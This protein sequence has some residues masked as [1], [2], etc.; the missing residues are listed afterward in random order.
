MHR[1]RQSSNTAK[2]QP[3]RL[4][5]SPDEVRAARRPEKT[6]V[7]SPTRME[8]L[9]GV[10]LRDL[11]PGWR[12][13]AALAADGACWVWGANARGELGPAFSR[14]RSIVRP[15]RLPGL[16]GVRAIAC[17]GRHALAVDAG[18]A[19]SVLRRQNLLSVFAAAP[20][21]VSPLALVAVSPRRPSW[22]RRGG[23]AAA[24][25]V[26][27][28]RRRRGL[29]AAPSRSRRGARRGLSAAPSA[30]SRRPELRRPR[31]P[32]PYPTRLVPT[33]YKRASLNAGTRGARTTTVSS[34]RRGGPTRRRR[35]G[36]CGSP[37]R[38]S[39]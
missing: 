24:P 21:A 27:S 15:R 2:S 34:A 33:P 36:A 1:W 37:R 3:T 25:V 5:V 13:G 35:S 10:F 8:A 39:S 31:V 16:S 23:L 26:V 20:V 29:V 11:R 7:T 22:P 19:L 18:G 38:T 14:D 12:H 30:S 9:K 6:R 4:I 32:T 17:G 28:P